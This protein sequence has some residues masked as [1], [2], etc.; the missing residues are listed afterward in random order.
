MAGAARAVRIPRAGEGPAATESSTEAVLTPA[1]RSTEHRFTNAAGSSRAFRTFVFFLVALAVI[2]A[3][4]LDLAVSS[5]T[6]GSN[7]SVEEVLTAAVVISLGIGWFVTFGQTPSGAWVEGGQLVVHERTGRF[8]RFP[9]DDV[10]FHVLRSN[11]VGIFGP[12][13]TEYVEVFAPRAGRR[14]Y[15]VGTHFFD[16][17]Q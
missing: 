5:S 12:E 14:T 8:R 10:K 17:A 2:Y 3:V 6:G 7:Y 1:P 11:E 13:P 4:F 9:Q 15:L 16:F